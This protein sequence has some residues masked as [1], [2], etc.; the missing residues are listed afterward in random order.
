LRRHRK[1]AGAGGGRR[2]GRLLPAARSAGR[3]FAPPRP[4]RRTG[5]R[6]DRRGETA[7]CVRRGWPAAPAA[8]CLPP[9]PSDG[10]TACS[11][12]VRLRNF[13]VPKSVL[14]A[15]NGNLLRH[16]QRCICPASLQPSARAAARSRR[17]HVGLLAAAPS[18]GWGPAGRTETDE[19]SGPFVTA[20][21]GGSGIGFL[22]GRRAGP[23]SGV[24]GGRDLQLPRADVARAA[25][26][27]A[28]GYL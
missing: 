5:S 6:P 27:V 20:R 1:A 9:A 24:A 23:G 11:A 15:R 4:A 2:A 25:R 16:R 19:E 22:S 21:R 17:P 3:S 10:R 8:G 18:R 14:Q 12:T 28:D 7:R 26:E 13:T